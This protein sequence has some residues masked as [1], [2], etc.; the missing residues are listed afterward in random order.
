MNSPQI[1]QNKDHLI[2]NHLIV[3]KM[4]VKVYQSIKK[5]S[6]LS[7]RLLLIIHLDSKNKMK[8]MMNMMNMKIS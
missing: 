5:I 2:V 7:K 3:E 1:Y 4:K 6:K 8:N